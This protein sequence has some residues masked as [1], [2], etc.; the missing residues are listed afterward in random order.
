MKRYSAS[1]FR[2]LCFPSGFYGV[3]YKSTWI[4][5]ALISRK[6]AE[7]YIRRIIKTG[8]LYVF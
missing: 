3:Q 8:C 1:D 5:A 7:K 4:N 2:V 6:A